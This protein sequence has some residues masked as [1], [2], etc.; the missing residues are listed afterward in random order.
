M[1]TAEMAAAVTQKNTNSS[2]SIMY[3]ASVLG[4]D[5]GDDRVGKNVVGERRVEDDS[6]FR[7]G[8]E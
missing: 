8:S 1:V 3:H 7:D 6:G 5:S 2:S 4:V